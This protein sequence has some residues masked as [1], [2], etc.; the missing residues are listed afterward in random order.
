MTPA[1]QR[2]PIS[3]PLAYNLTS[4]I[5]C[6]NPPNTCGT[7][8]ADHLSNST[9][10]SIHPASKYELS[11][12]SGWSQLNSALKQHTSNQPCMATCAP[13]PPAS[14]MTP[15]GLGFRV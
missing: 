2:P 1:R 11:E 14:P 10:H 7:C 3:A 4:A 13:Y 12:L 6:Q 5:I 9:W 15:Q 8:Q